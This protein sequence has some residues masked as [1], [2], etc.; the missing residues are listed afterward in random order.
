M[1]T[2]LEK[3]KTYE[4]DKLFKKKGYAFFDRGSYNLNI[5][6]IRSNQGN[7]VTNK[8]DDYFVVIYKDGS[9]KWNRK[10][11]SGT[12][13]PGLDYV[14]NLTNP[15]GVAI[16][17]PGQYRGLWKIALHS[18]KYEALC[19]RTTP[20]KV[21]RDGNKDDKFDLLPTKIDTG[22]FGINMHRSSQFGKST[23]V[24]KYSAG[25]Q[26]FADAKDF[27]EMMKLAK[28]QVSS[29]MGTTFTY[30]LLDESE[31]T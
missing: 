7:K 23:F 19:Q 3:L 6:G 9:N 8:F 13:E 20:V 28:L 31:L 14:K 10:I 26:V 12:T 30:T 15:K 2:L 18:G 17:V 5:I 1:S 25:C 27:N 24:G 22:I 16:V 4:F 21:Y 29:G 11:W